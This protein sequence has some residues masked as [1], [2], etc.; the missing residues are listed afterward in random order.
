MEALPRNDEIFV[1][2]R[3]T[4]IG[5]HTGFP[6]VLRASSGQRDDARDGASDPGAEDCCDHLR[7]CMRREVILR[8]IAWNH[9]RGFPPLV[10]TAQRFE[11]L[12]PGVEIRW[13][14]RSLHDFGHADLRPLAEYYD[15]AVIDHPMMGIARESHALLDLNTLLDQPFVAE[16]ASDSAGKSY[17]SYCYKEGLFALP[18]DA[19]APAASYRPD[20]LERRGAELPK[21]WDDVLGLAR[22]KL[23][24]MPGFHVDVFLN[25]LALYVS[26]RGTAV[27]DS[28]GSFDGETAR[29]CLNQMRELASCMPDE[30]YAW[31][32]IRIY[33]HMVATDLHAYCPFAYTY[34]NYSRAGF[35]ER[36]LLF[37]NPVA[38]SGDRPLRTVLGGTGLAISARCKAVTVALS[39]AKCVTSAEWQRT[40][41]ALSGGQ[42]SR[43]SAW[44]DKTVNQVS[45]GFFERTL[46]TVE[47][48]FLRPRYP[49]YIQFQEAA[50]LSIV[51]YL[52]NGGNPTLVVRK[53][54]ALYRQTRHPRKSGRADPSP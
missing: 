53:L 29:I 28:E 19:A 51:E 3:L 16:L 25:F 43:R 12:Q 10:A 23:V 32:P 41:Y 27:W 24:I 1:E 35:A 9:S 50:G 4:G 42:P 45:S 22:R 38:L 20:L 52:R 36:Q 39:Y 21:S 17:E 30:I 46:N 2:A 11:E 34:S 31:N 49:G 54:E 37:S 13:E 47:S 6:G 14:K 44:Q 18:I 26:E 48:A 33:E 40:L 15:L 5:H 8:G 7:C